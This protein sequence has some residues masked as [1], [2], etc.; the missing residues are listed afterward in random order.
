MTT[1]CLTSRVFDHV[2]R[3]GTKVSGCRPGPPL[4]A[5]AGAKVSADDRVDPSFFGGARETCVGRAL[6]TASI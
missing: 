6:V 5:V 1:P 2:A 4:V 3:A